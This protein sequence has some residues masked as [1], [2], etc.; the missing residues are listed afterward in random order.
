L[1]SGEE[2]SYSESF[3]LK[4]LPSTTVV[5]SV[6]KDP[7]GREYSKISSST[8]K[9]ITVD[10]DSSEITATVTD[11]EGLY[12]LSAHMGLYTFEAET[13]YGDEIDM[14]GIHGTHEEVVKRVF[15]AGL[16]NALKYDLSSF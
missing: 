1:R 3:T 14:A 16:K 6:K 15:E 7:Y 13:R 4:G 10:V 12:K 2:G 9:K 5:W 8:K 11:K